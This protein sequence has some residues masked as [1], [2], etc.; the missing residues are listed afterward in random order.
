MHEG[1]KHSIKSN[2][3]EPRIENAYLKEAILIVSYIFTFGKKKYKF[4]S[5]KLYV[6]PNATLKT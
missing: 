4:E 3:V 6:F 2:Y 5:V 1:I